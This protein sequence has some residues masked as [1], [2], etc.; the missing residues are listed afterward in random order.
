MTIDILKSNKSDL[1]KLIGI[2][3]ENGITCKHEIAQALNKSVRTVER[4]YAELRRDTQ[5]RVY[6]DTRNCVD[7]NADLRTETAPSRVRAPAQKEYSSN[8]ALASKGEEELT[9]RIDFFAEQLAGL[10]AGQMGTPNVETAKTVVVSNCH[11]YTADMVA[12]AINE[13]ITKVASGD[14]KNPTLK[15]FSAYCKEAK[16]ARKPVNQFEK[17]M[18]GILGGATFHQGQAA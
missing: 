12:I 14:L 4:G 3:V 17:T 9:D 10:I 18:A 1:A 5:D 15:T 8:I 6:A 16:P 7:K 11:A 2:C 13:M